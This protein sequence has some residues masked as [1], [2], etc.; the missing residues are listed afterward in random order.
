MGI[1]TALVLGS[2]FAISSEES[3]KRESKAAAGLKRQAAVRIAAGKMGPETAAPLDRPSEQARK[4]RLR[5]ASF[6]TRD[7]QPPKLGF[8]GLLGE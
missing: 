3:R 8:A 7:W 2:L 5:Q 6:L 1:E 4:S